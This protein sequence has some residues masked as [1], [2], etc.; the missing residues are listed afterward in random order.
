[1]SKL[2]ALIVFLIAGEAQSQTVKLV[3]DG[4]NTSC[5]TWLESRRTTYNHY[6]ATWALGY[7]SGVAIW[8]QTLNPLNSVDAE[9]VFYWLDNYCREHPIDKF[10][11]ALAAFVHEHPR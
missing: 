1:M 10:S 6:M 7:L 4:A 2:I 8:S 9:G 3:G 11:N 5:G